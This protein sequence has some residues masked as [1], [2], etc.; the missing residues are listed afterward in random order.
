MAMRDIIGQ[1]YVQ[2]V[3]S[4]SIK[5]ERVAHAYLL[6]GEDGA[7]KTEM[8]L[9][10]AKALNCSRG[11]GDSCDAC[12]SCRKVEAGN[13]PDVRVITPDGVSLKIAQMRDLSR[14]AWMRPLEGEWKVF[15]IEQAHKMTTE[16]GN[17]LLKLL[18]EPPGRAVLV[19]TCI[20]PWGLLPTIVSRCQVIEFRP[21]APE[22]IERA[23][24]QQGTPPD[25]AR[26]LAMFSNG[27]LRKALEFW[28]SPEFTAC[29][30]QVVEWFFALEAMD[31]AQVLSL[32]QEVTGQDGAAPYVLDL[33]QGLFRDLLV[34][35]SGGDTESRQVPV[36]NLDKQASLEGKARS[37][38]VKAALKGVK[39]I[40]QTKQYLDG[41]VNRRLAL[42]VMFFQLQ[43]VL[44]EG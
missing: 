2:R 37:I 28:N 33:F 42:E 14:E 10:F 43:S 32:A 40:E 26:F 24:V 20:Q 17:S 18:E 6:V 11:D 22:D 44:K 25:T 30:E 27:V 3:L 9:N 29:R 31:D 12:L 35:T 36:M 41:N 16:A 23:L 1:E 19:L 8:A 15:I 7:Q 5:K 39:I 4:N 13:H 38:P 34:L 21:V